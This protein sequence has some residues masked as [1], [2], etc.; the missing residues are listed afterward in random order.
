MRPGFI[1]IAG[2]VV[3]ALSCTS[4]I[5]VPANTELTPDQHVVNFPI[6]ADPHNI[7]DCNVC[8]GGTSSFRQ[9]SCMNGT[10]HPADDTMNVHSNVLG[11]EYVPVGCYA[12]HKTGV[13]QGSPDHSTLFPIGPGDSHG[14]VPCAACHMN[15]DDRTI[16]TCAIE[17]CHGQADTALQHMNVANY[18]WTSPQCVSCHPNG[19][20]PAQ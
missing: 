18:V 1:C 10:C 14:W 13:A 15:A 7:S 8:H 4:H 17:G 2:G 9:F 3:L 16:V 5:D 19:T 20:T 11:Y 12:C 6:T